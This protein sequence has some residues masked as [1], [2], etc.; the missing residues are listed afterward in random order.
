MRDIN[1]TQERFSKKFGYS[2]QEKEIAIR[3]G[4]PQG[5]RQFMIQTLYEFGYQPSQLRQTICMTL[6]Q[7]PDDNNWSEYPN[8]D[9]EIR[10]L[11]K[12][13]EWFQVYDIIEAF[14]SYSK[15]EEKQQA[16]ADE[17]NDY[18]KTNG[19][20]WKLENGQI[21]FRGD[22]IFETHLR[23]AEKTL[24]LTDLQTAKNEIKEAIKDISKRPNPDIT[25][26]VQ[27][28][29]A[30]LECVAREITGDKKLT[31]GELIKK[32]R[33]IVPA[34]LDT[35]IEKMWG[36]S[37][38]QGRHLQ[39]GKEPAFDEVEL[40]VG[41]SASISTYLARKSPKFKEAGTTNFLLKSDIL[42]SK[43]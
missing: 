24:D 35:V 31:L 20:G 26:A 1:M 7:A 3:E 33:E 41:L 22:E 38:E 30:C 11:I 4:A 42:I 17:I 14:Y 32:N 25:G 23:K 40:L 29:I 9:Y 18:F 39:E 10:N 13:C 37:S 43:M 15:I 16:F 6:R 8:I 36:F 19:I 21:L 27:H 34:P 2:T 12:N 5:L 28:S